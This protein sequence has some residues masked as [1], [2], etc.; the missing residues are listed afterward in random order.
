MSVSTAAFFAFALFVIHEFEEIIRVFPWIKKYRNNP[1]YKQ[2][3][4]ISRK[5][6]YPSTECISIMIGE[7]I[8]LLSIILTIGIVLNSILIILAAIIFNTI[9]LVLHILSA[10][11]IRKWNPGSISSIITMFL[12]IVLL[13]ILFL[14]GVEIVKL[15]IITV[16]TVV[17]FMLNINILYRFA[18]KI[19]EKIS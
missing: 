6:N 2:D 9:H 18:N 1:E 17:V 15:V 7:E 11:A 14:H 4:W 13:I 16:I 3:L 8:V 12:N 5:K 19:Q 10:I